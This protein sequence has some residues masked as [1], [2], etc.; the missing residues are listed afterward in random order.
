MTG[1]EVVQP[2]PI[3]GK[4]CSDPIPPG[5][6]RS[7]G[8]EMT[9]LE[10]ETLWELFQAIGTHWSDLHPRAA[11]SSTLRS[12]W[13][14]FLDAK[15]NHDP[16]YTAEYANA[17]MVIN[18]LKSIY[19]HELEAY[20]MLFFEHG[21]PDGPPMTRLAHAKTY[22]VNEFIR[23]NV[24]AS[25]FRSFGRPDNNGRNYKGFLGGSRFNLRA[26][27]RDFVPSKEGK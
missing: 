22:V 15:T 12:S 24:V 26:R 18:E 5:L 14:E 23:V 9:V 20:G 11:D 27:V 10:R 19:P 8:Q 7:E 6:I 17:V 21:L 2:C 13:L 3:G 4:F 25:G 1:D 16:S